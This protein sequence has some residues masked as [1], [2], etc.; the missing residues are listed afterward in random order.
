MVGNQYFYSPGG[1]GE[2]ELGG[3]GGENYGDLGQQSNEEGDDEQEGEDEDY[4][5]DHAEN[6]EEQRFD[7]YQMQLNDREPASR[8]AQIRNG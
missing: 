2:G 6:G 8:G 1:L 4:S 7:E 5:E 3:R